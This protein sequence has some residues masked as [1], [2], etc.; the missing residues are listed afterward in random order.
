M[1][2]ALTHREFPCVMPLPT[3]WTQ[4]PTVGNVNVVICSTAWR[5]IQLCKKVLWLQNNI[6]LNEIKHLHGVFPLLFY[7]SVKNYIWRDNFQNAGNS[8]F[9]FLSHACSRSFS[10]FLSYLSNSRNFRTLPQNSSATRMVTGF[11]LF[12]AH[13][14]LLLNWIKSHTA[15]THNQP[16][17]LDN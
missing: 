15:S 7:Y 6:N 11:L 17:Q 2:A 9:F 3:G 10:C 12:C 14:T 4:L 5:F 1:R 8:P 16:Y 13:R